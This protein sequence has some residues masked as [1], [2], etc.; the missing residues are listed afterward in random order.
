M[1][2]WQLGARGVIVVVIVLAVIAV[3]EWLDK[4]LSYP[5]SFIVTAALMLLVMACAVLSS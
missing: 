2:Y 1:S 3:M 5:A 4:R